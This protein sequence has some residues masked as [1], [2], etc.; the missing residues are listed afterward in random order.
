MNVRHLP[1]ISGSYRSTAP[2]LSMLLGAPFAAGC[3]TGWG[4]GLQFLVSATRFRILLM[5][6]SRLADP[7]AVIVVLAAAAGCNGVAAVSSWTLRMTSPRITRE[8][9]RAP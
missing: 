3:P 2:F 6:G 4:G 1:V 7:Y 9:W 8:R 5:I